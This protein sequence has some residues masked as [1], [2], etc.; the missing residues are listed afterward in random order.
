[1]TERQ[2]VNSRIQGTAADITG[3][4]MLKCEAD[5]DLRMLGVRMLLQ[6]HD[7]LMF[8]VPD[9]PELIQAAKE[10]IRFLM[11]DPFEMLVPIAISMSD[12]YTWGEAK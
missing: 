9:I 12:A 3:R 6:I 7:E 10:R 5:E 8:E 2:A 4:A 11:E 1:M